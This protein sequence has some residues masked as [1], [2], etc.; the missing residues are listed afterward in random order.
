[1]KRERVGTGL[2][3]RQYVWDGWESVALLLGT[4]GAMLESWTRGAGLAGDI[5]TLVAVTHHGGSWTNGTYYTHHDH[6]GDIILT[7]SGT[8]T[9][10]RYDYSAFGTLKSQVGPDVC[11]FKFSSK[12]RDPATGWS[13]YGYRYYAPAWQRWVSA[14]PIGE[15]GGFGLYLFVFNRPGSS[16]DAFGLIGILIKPVLAVKGL[17]AAIIGYMQLLAEQK[18][19]APRWRYAHCMASCHI[20]RSCGPGTA[21]GAG[22]LKELYDLGS[23]I[24]QAVMTGTWNSGACASAFQPID[25]VDNFYGILGGMMPGA[26]FCGPFRTCAAHCAAHQS[27]PEGASG[28]FYQ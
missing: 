11:R 18:Q 3:I 28:P 8:S 14:D 9:V 6:R 2:H 19:A 22:M 15:A 16:V 5:G 24:R 27:A 23:C 26:P 13:Y 21:V 4:S 17:C 1:M 12:E 10:G 7:R 25:F 20:A